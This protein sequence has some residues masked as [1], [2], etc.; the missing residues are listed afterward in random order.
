M[1]T[2]PNNDTI[3]HFIFKNK[4]E[5]YKL[6]LNPVRQYIK[7]ATTYVSKQLNMPREDANRIVLDKIK[8]TKTNNPIVKYNHRQD[9]GDVIIAEDKLTDYLKAALENGD[10]IA[11]SFTTYIHPSVKKSLHANFLAINIAKRKQDKH[12]EFSYKQE[13]NMEKSKYH[14]IMQKTRKI[15]NNALSGSYASKSTVLYNPTAHYTLTSI[16]RSVASIGNAITES[17]IA[18]NKHFKSSE[19]VNNYITAIISNIN[20]KTVEVALINYKLYIP[21]PNDV[22]DMILYSSKY[23]WRDDIA[24]ANILKYLNKLTGTELAAVLYLNDLW[25]VKKYNPEF[26]K[27]MITRLSTKYKHISKDP[28]RDLTKSAEGVANLAHCICFDEIRGV[29]IDY[30]QLQG[31]DL[32]DTLG[33]TAY[34]ITE[35]LNYY[36]L[37]FRAF[38]TT[39]ILPPTIA[40][41]KDM[42]RDSIVLSDTD[43]TCGAYD[44]WVEWYFG[45][46]RFDTSAI[47]VSSALMTI[48]V[49]L[50]DHNIKVFARN[51]NIDK[52]LIELLKMK[53]EFLWSTFTATNVSKHYFADTIMQEGNVFANS[54]REVKGVHLIASAA[55]QSIV[56]QVLAIIDEIHKKIGSGEKISLFEYATKIADIERDILAKIENG[57]TIIYRTDKIKE[58]AA[59]KLD[60]EKSPY[61]HHMLWEEVF[62]EKYGSPGNPTYLVIKIPT[63]LTS[64][65]LMN[66]FIDNIKDEQI[67]TKLRNF[68]TKYGKV[69]IGTFRAPIAVVSNTGVPVEF[70]PIIDSK[71]IVTDMLY[72]G[73]LVLESIGLFRKSELLVSELGY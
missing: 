21:T 64:P 19:I 27:E 28:I 25:H 16:T 10:V 60:K 32:L 53:N 41:I 42:M 20:M 43:S 30:K 31:T 34:K 57:S 72:S 68:L 39:N 63:T 55:E 73:Y 6:E 71:R 17:I 51:L 58:E 22:M 52:D 49:Q 46:N 13:G 11:P 5:E 38:Y 26:V 1:V 12:L 61:F 70:I 62:A 35:A 7:Q 23:Y 66:E 67:K 2:E 14:N 29:K 24:E 40:Y 50:M 37:L 9:N 36:K 45:E 59:Y 44:K 56:K 69:R 47:A 18:G 8:N 65:K 54:D 48:N 3:D 4:P 15:Q 33:S